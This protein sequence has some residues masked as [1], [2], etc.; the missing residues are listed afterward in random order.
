MS[1]PRFRLSNGDTSADVEF[2]TKEVS[3]IEPPNPDFLR[4]HAAF[5]KVLHISGAAEFM[6]RLETDGERPVP[7]FMH[8]TNDFGLI[9]DHR[10]AVLAN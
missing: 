3:G 4:V 10:L 8:P 2:P 6:D 7:L 5:A 1:R 9:L